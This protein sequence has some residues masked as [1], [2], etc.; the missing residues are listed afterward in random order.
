MQTVYEDGPKRD[1]R[2]WIGDLYLEALA[3]DC[4]YRQH[5]LTRRC[6]YLLAG[7]ADSTGVLAGTLFE[8]PEPHAQH[9]QFLLDYSLLYNVTLK[10]YLTAT[11]DRKTAESLWPVVFRQLENIRPYLRKNGLLDYERANREWWVFFDWRDGLHKEVSLHGLTVFAFRETRELARMLG[12]EDE[13]AWL[14]PTIAKMTAA[15]RKHYLDQKTGLYVGTTDRQVSYSSQVWMVLG[16]IASQ[17]EGQRALRALGTASGVVRPGTPYAY[18]YYIQALI[19]CGMTDEARTALCDYW[20]GMVRKGADTF[21]EAYSPDDDF[22]SPYGF[23]PMNSY[24][25]AWSCTPVYFIRTYPEIFQ[26]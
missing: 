5:A 2:L 10:N 13:V 4:S 6:L 20:G 8:R 11:A 16:G 9:K 21:W 12:K 18:H 15:A 14:G 1:Q 19:D 25:H 23:C 22:L 17:K 3:N 26:R 7:C 24:C